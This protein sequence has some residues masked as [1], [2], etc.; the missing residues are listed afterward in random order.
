MNFTTEVE[1]S[2][3]HR[4]VSNYADLGLDHH[5]CVWHDCQKVHNSQIISHAGW[6]NHD[7]IRVVRTGI[8][9][10][11]AVIGKLMEVADTCH[12]KNECR[13]LTNA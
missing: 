11:R 4:Y 5:S 10:R 3:S 1:G 2:S 13:E 7:L 8:D 6:V 12:E 9:V